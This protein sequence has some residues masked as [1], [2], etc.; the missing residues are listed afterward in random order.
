MTKQ[1]NMEFSHEENI[2]EES[3]NQHRR[4]AAGAWICGEELS[5][6]GSASMTKANSDHG[7]FK[8][9]IDSKNA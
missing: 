2:H 3:V 1:G 4:M 6:D 9:A 5:E 8:S 7:N